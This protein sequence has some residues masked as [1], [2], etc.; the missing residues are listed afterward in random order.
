MAPAILNHLTLFRPWL[1]FL[2]KLIKFLPF[3]TGKFNLIVRV[4]S[5]VIEEFLLTN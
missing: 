2:A 5:P 4:I 3:S 1:F